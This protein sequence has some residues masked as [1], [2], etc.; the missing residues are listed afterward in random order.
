MKKDPVKA[1]KKATERDLK[2]RQA[3]AEKTSGAEAR[4][5]D[6]GKPS[7]AQRKANREFEAAQKQRLEKRRSDARQTM[8]SEEYASKPEDIPKEIGGRQVSKH[9]AERMVERD[10]TPKQVEKTLK[11]PLETKPIKVEDGRPSQKIVG[12][13]ATVSV[14]PETGKI[15]QTNPT[16]SSLKVRLLEKLGVK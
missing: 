16:E 6:D 9:A 15:I 5:A 14:N 2:G 11:D 8:N 13:E 12:E 10:V 4:K 7:D 1:R 3:A